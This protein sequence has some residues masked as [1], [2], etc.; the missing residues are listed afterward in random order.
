MA[1]SVPLDRR[2]ALRTLAASGLWPW[3]TGASA[4]VRAPDRSKVVLCL[5]LEPTGLDPTRSPAAS[6]AQVV[7]GNVFEGLT[8]IDERGN[9][10]PLLAESWQVDA[11]QQHWTFTLHRGVRFHDGRWLDASVVRFAF[12]RAQ[13]P[14]A[15]NKSRKALFDNIA[16]IDT[17]TPHTVVLHLHHP[18][19][20]LPFRL[21]ESAAVVLHPESAALASHY[22]VGTGPYRLREWRKGWGVVLEAFPGHREASR[23]QIP[24]AQF[25]FLNDPDQQ[26]AAVRAG[27]VDLLFNTATQTLHALRAQGPYQL[28]VGT[29]SGKG[30]LAL[31]HRRKPLND[32][33]VRRAITHAIDRQRFVDTVLA[34][35]G[36]AIGSHCSPSEA[37][38]VH[39]AGL[40]PYDPARAQALLAEA[41]T[42]G[43]A[44]TLAQPPT[45]YARLGGP[46]I[47][48]CL[49]KVGIAVTLQPMDWAQWMAGPFRGD[50]DLTLINHVEPYDV[51][52]YGDPAYYFGYDSP[53]YRELLARYAASPNARLRLRLF[54]DLQRHLAQ[55][56]VNA[57]IFAA[58]VTTVAR[59]GLRGWWMNYP[60]QAHDLVSLY[61]E[62]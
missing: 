4:W 18:D 58:R 9:V 3:G 55:D 10:Q 20:L 30:M 61:W 5:S 48:E 46:L 17:P 14:S 12:E 37:G 11:L 38:Y 60:I 57:W 25:R 52:M 21:G 8:R 15:T 24:Q 16:R 40:Y 33:R 43:L 51:Y 39:L 62:A 47:A 29:S 44:L 50:F 59:K 6:T 23:V 45:P 42:Q 31:N 27:E 49:A 13:A 22:P 53:T 32:L 26:I 34:G 19:G 28:A 2:S 1:A 35:Q 41:G 36:T 56:A 54:A 7:H